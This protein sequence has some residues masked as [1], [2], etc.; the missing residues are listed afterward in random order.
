MGRPVDDYYS[1]QCN[2]PSLPSNTNTNPFAIQNGDNRP[3]TPEGFEIS[4]H[5]FFPINAPASRRVHV[6][7]VLSPSQFPDEG[8]ELDDTIFQLSFGEGQSDSETFV[9]AEYYGDAASSTIR[10]YRESSF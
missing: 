2:M 3:S 9:E 10:I 8:E 6:Q 5:N 7:P 4:T 1:H